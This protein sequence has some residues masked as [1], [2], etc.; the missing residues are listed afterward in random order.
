MPLTS[1][2]KHYIK[3]NAGKLQIFQLAENLNL[4]QKEVE[5]Y[6]KKKLGNKKF[7]TSSTNSPFSD[8]LQ[9]NT[10]AINFK[11]FFLENI[12]VF[13]FL[14]ILVL[15]VYA[16]SI[17]NQFVS[18]DVSVIKNNPE[19][20]KFSLVFSNFFSIIQ[21]F[22]YYIAYH[23][24]GG[25]PWAFRSFNVALHFGS[26]ILLFS[27]LK[28][29]IGKRVAVLSAAILAVH[30]M[31]VESITWIS[32]M[33]YVLYSFF[34][35]LAFLFYVTADDGE[36]KDRR[37][38]SLLFFFLA[39]MSSE[40]AIVF[41][42]ILFIF[43][44]SRYALKINWKKLIPFFS[45]DLA[46]VLFYVSRIGKRVSDI[47]AV[48]YQDSSGLYNPFIQVPTAIANYLKLLFWPQKLSLYQTEM[49]FSPPQ[50]VFMVIVFLS[51]LGIIF[52]AWKK[53]R[54]LFFWLSLLIVSLLPVLTPLKIAWVVAERYA[55][56]GSI[57]IFV[58][59]AIFFDWFIS[60]Y[61]KASDSYKK[62]AYAVF[63]III[64]A[65]SARTIYRNIDWK[66][67]DHLWVATAKVASSGP[68]IHNNMGDVHARH[69][70]L[71][72]AAE[73]F[74]KAIQINPN[75]GDAYHNLANTYTSLG[76]IDLAIENYQKALS[77]NPN[78]WQSH[79]NLAS[80]YYSIGNYQKAYE[81]ISKALEINPGNQDLQK[82][83]EM[84]E[85]AMGKQ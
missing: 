24:G 66:D 6:I 56:L 26:V 42:G 44:L 63:G 29:L 21:M 55:Y 2:Q 25:A 51:L 18:D 9:N 46:F 58:A 68:N 40:K 60:R 49:N 79:Q 17:T 62:A 4:P 76:K 19:M 69:G 16:N 30:P 52:W 10:L 22:L 23:L 84:V 70:E 34:I 33:P 14:F 12:N 85:Q 80:V 45:L 57:G 41:P 32:G 36:H 11:D 83:K 31:M 67:E 48:S 53:N 81:E 47:S 74:K 7:I 38:N 35:L 1:G 77:I 75:Y 15:A 78:I 82:N 43:E 28:L 20:G 64:A 3:K 8:N 37:Y 50:F 61:S 54:N 59:V 27:I 5:R 13:I 65:L 39:I 71:E 72:A 73:E